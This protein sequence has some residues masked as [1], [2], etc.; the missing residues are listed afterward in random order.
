MPLLAVTVEAVEHRIAQDLGRQ[1]LAGE[2]KAHGIEHGRRPAVVFGNLI[3]ERC[4]H[5]VGSILDQCSILRTLIHRNLQYI[6]R[7]FQ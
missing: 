3:V 2:E 1:L 5:R 7:L 6:H 4:F